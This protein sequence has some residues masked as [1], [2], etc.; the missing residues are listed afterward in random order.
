LAALSHRRKTGKG[1][2]ID[3]AQFESGISFLPHLVLDYFANGRVREACGN[4]NLFAA[5]HGVYR[6]KG[7]DRWCAIAVSSDQEWGNFRKVIGKPKWSQEARFDTLPGRKANE[8]ELDKLVEEW[9][10]NYPAEEVMK[11]M[12]KAGVAAGVVQ[13]SKDLC[14]DPQLQHRQHFVMLEQAEMGYYP[15]EAAPFRLSKTPA[16]L[17][18]GAPCLGEHTQFVCNE[19]LGISDEEFN[20]LVKDGAF[21]NPPR[22][23][24]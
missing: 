10:I 23:K 19:I 4:R 9:T 21:G 5:P 16:E 3:L 6:C 22:E 15:H 2:Y 17:R 11:M 14:E 7:D 1:T 13:N 24:E 18:M 8:D 12:Q 20:N